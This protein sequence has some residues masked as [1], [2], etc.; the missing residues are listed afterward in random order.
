MKKISLLFVILSLALCSNAQMKISA[1]LTYYVATGK[2]P[3]DASSG[4]EKPSFAGQGTFIYPRYVFNQK[5]KSSLSVG[6]PLTLALSGGF[7]SVAGSNLTFALDL[8]VTVDYNIG[9][10]GTDAD[11]EKDPKTFGAFIGAGFGYTTS[12]AQYSYQDSLY[13]IK[14]AKAKTFGPMIHAGVKAFVANRN[15]MLRVA[16]KMGFEKLK[17]NTVFVSLGTEF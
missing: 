8:P 11:K 7:N 12:N 16:Y 15:Y 10:G 4:T 6:I 17:F 9:L 13:I 3:K 2:V 5:E 1:G 14:Y